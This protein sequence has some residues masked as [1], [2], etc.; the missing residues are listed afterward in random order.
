VVGVDSW[1]LWYLTRP[2][3]KHAFA[4]S[5]IIFTRVCKPTPEKY[6]ANLLG[7]YI[8]ETLIFPCMDLVQR[9]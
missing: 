9:I 1:T 8:A 7:I 6:S 5:G 2:H 3:V 4:T